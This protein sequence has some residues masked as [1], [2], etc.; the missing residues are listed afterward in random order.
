MIT[1]QNPPLPSAMGTKVENEQS[2]FDP[3]STKQQGVESYTF[4]AEPKALQ[5]PRKKYK[6]SVA[7][8][9]EKDQKAAV[10]IMF[11]RRIHRGNTYASPVL[12]LHAQ[13][14]PVEVQK[15]AELKRR[16]KAKRK[17]EAQ[18]LIRTPEPVDGRRHIDVQTELYLEELSD[19]VP[20]SYAATQTDAFLDRAPSPL[21]IPQKSGV[22]VATQ[23]YEG[24]L[25]DFD[26]EVQPI[27]EVLVGKTLEQALME[28]MEEEELEMLRK[29][30]LEFEERRNAEMAEVQRLE[31][32]ERRRTE[33]KERRLIEKIRILKEK[34]E[35]AER[36][37]ARAFAQSYLQNLL[38]A[39][40]DSLATNGYFYD[41]VE[42]E[43]DSMF[44]P[45]LTAEANKSL[46]KSNTARS[47]VDDIIGNAVRNLRKIT[48]G[49]PAQQ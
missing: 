40:F 7:A 9:A 3:H 33:E 5:A 42:K 21:Y 45:W 25:F 32:A 12:P 17:A 36:I 31:D 28:V 38:P 8:A 11:D 35:V 14:D 34:Q 43:I 37:A 44:L 30:Q 1:S 23:V 46:D 20:E 13:P 41:T 15:H 16:L 2:H 26:F 10:N 39:V 19:K 27:L 18:R 48:M 49:T 6:D 22:D 24:E 47:L 29:R 4:T